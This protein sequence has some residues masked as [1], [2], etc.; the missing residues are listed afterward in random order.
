MP[1]RPA[2]LAMALLACMAQR[3]TLVH[4]RAASVKCDCTVQ[5]LTVRADV[6]AHVDGM[7]ALSCVTWTLAPAVSGCILYRRSEKQM[8]L[9]GER[10][11]QKGLCL[12]EASF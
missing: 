6:E 2:S 3:P 8:G 10:S 4:C 12:L 9:V 7:R 5:V 11:E 1:R